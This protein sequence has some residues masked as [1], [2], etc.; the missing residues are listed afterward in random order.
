MTS[1][2]T[3]RDKKSNNSGNV[4]AHDWERSNGGAV[5]ELVLNGRQYIR[6]GRWIVPE[7]ERPEEYRNVIL[8][9]E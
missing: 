1:E 3:K 4:W 6:A 9:G 5:R 2:R 8:A 7:H